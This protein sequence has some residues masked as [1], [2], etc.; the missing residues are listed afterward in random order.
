MTQVSAEERQKAKATAANSAVAANDAAV[1]LGV[2]GAVGAGAAVATG[3]GAL[4]GVRD[5]PLAGRVQLRRVVGREPL[6]AARD[7]PPRTDFAIVTVSAAA[8]PAGGQS[9]TDAA[10]AAKLLGSQQIILADA[11]DSLV[12]SLERYDGALAAGDSDAA[13]KQADAARQNAAATKTAQQIF[14]DLAATLNASWQQAP[15]DL[16]ST[17]VD[18]VK[19]N[20]LAAAGPPTQA[21]GETLQQALDSVS[22][23]ANAQP[24]A[25]LCADQDPVRA[26]TQ[27]PASLDVLIGPALL[28]AMNQLSTTLDALVNDADLTLS[29]PRGGRRGRSRVRPRAGHCDR[30]LPAVRRRLHELFKFRLLSIEQNLR[31]RQSIHEWSA[32]LIQ[33]NFVDRLGVGE[34]RRAQN[35]DKNLYRDD[36]AGEAIDHLAGATGEVDK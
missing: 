21:A 18:A 19:S 16:S 34:A 7:D 35:D 14:A 33:M 11:L 2:V 27:T 6:S 30:L 29:G 31:L 28:D 23:L 15:L 36:L 1:A 25:D 20:Y 12:T 32:A 24:F 5:R 10:I 3:V 4:A 9:T 22:G 13:Q 17:T 26:L 8:L